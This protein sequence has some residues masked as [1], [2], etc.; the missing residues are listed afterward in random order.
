VFSQRLLVILTE[1]RHLIPAG[2]FFPF[3]RHFAEKFAWRRENAA[4]SLTFRQ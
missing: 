1:G 4:F 3:L 2:F